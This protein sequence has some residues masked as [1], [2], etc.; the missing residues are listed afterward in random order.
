MT[1]RKPQLEVSINWQKTEFSG[2]RKEWPTKG[3]WE[4]EDN[5]KWTYVQD[6]PHL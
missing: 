4:K 3:Y 6:M 5:K 1:F 2:R